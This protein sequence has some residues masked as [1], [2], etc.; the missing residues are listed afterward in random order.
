MPFTFELGL[1]ILVS[2]LN[3]YSASAC[4]PVKYRSLEVKRLHSAQRL[5]APKC[6][7]HDELHH[8]RSTVCLQKISQKS[9]VTFSLV[10]L[11]LASNAI[12][13]D[14]LIVCVEVGEPAFSHFPATIISDATRASI[15]PSQAHV[16]AL[17][18]A[19]NMTRPEPDQAKPSTT[20]HQ[21]R[22]MI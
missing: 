22:L 15:S 3:M 8:T 20:L 18:S 21:C 2:T 14:S 12:P 19:Q 13:A 1:E 5:L 9:H 6:I 10:A 7:N 4:D 11:A 17:G 16:W